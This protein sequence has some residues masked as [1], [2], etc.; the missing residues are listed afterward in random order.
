MIFFASSGLEPYY[1]SILNLETV[2]QL[3]S[4]VSRLLAGSNHTSE[5]S[6]HARMTVVLRKLHTADNEAGEDLARVVD[7]QAYRKQ[8]RKNEF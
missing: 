2:V 6:T 4:F 7:D 3:D 8:R 5:R 1:L